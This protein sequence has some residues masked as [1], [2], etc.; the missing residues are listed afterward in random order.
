MASAN[1]E[2]NVHLLMLN[3]N[4]ELLVVKI[5]FLADNW[6]NWMML[7]YKPFWKRSD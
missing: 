7:L 2:T 6:V 1:T 5:V 3:L 4:Y